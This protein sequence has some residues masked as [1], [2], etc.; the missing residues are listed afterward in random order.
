MGSIGV[1]LM[2]SRASIEKLQRL[3]N[4]MMFNVHVRVLMWQWPTLGEAPA[5]GTQ[6]WYLSRTSSVLGTRNAVLLVKRRE[7]KQEFRG[8][9]W[10]SLLMLNCSE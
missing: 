1:L 10:L 9:S 5:F 3:F 2:G 7:N 6:L 8:I 4:V